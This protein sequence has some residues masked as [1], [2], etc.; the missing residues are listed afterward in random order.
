[1][2]VSSNEWT[3]RKGIVSFSIT[4]A[5][6]VD[7]WVSCTKTVTV[8][9][10]CQGEKTTLK[11]GTE[12]RFRQK[13]KGFSQIKVA[14]TGQTPFGLKVLE[15]PLEELD[16]NSGERPPVVE[17]PEP[18]NLVARFREMAR[19]HHAG[20]RWPVLE[21][22]DTPSFGRYEIEDDED[23]LFEEEAWSKRQEEKKAAA[24][25]A[26]ARKEA[27]AT[28]ASHEPPQ[29]PTAAP[30]PAKAVDP[31]PPATAAE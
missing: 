2:P 15:R 27:E 16:Y 26:K 23:V 8:F 10:V 9:G 24:A 7:I 17:L 14:G 4:E 3:S 11:A 1:M 28:K 30:E 6:M 5:H 12:F 19:A 31:P 20:N 29:Q 25:E 21:P 13:I 18:S 22:E